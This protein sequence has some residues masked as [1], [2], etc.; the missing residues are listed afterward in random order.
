MAVEPTG[1]KLFDPFLGE[2]DAFPGEVIPREQETDFDRQKRLAAQPYLDLYNLA[3]QRGGLSQTEL[4][5]V[6]KAAQLAAEAK[7]AELEEAFKAN[8]AA[9]I[10]GIILANSAGSNFTIPVD[11]LDTAIEEL[12]E[13]DKRLKQ[14]DIAQG[15]TP[16][17]TL[18][19]FPE[20][21]IFELTKINT[22]RDPDP[23]T[24]SNIFA[25]LRDLGGLPAPGIS[26]FSELLQI[27]PAYFPGNKPRPPEVTLYREA[28][29]NTNKI[30]GLKSN[31][32]G[33][34]G[35]SFRLGIN[36]DSSR[37]DEITP[38][39]LDVL[40]TPELCAK[41]IDTAAGFKPVRPPE[42]RRL[43]A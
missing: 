19:Y 28:A 40:S 16:R 38:Y 5:G 30:A 32:P 42:Q 20:K 17:R 34:E 27:I 15:K 22:G 11:I 10:Q 13:T 24:T 23:Q 9:I 14:G 1:D 7:G 37:R 33:L 41:I 25:I 12:I 3:A 2:R 35:V 29:T 36:Q 6:L 26:N 31:R 18:D 21:G 8:P 39:Y 4:I 43:R